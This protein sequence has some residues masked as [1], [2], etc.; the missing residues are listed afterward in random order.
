MIY[1]NLNRVKGILSARQGAEIPKFTTGGTSPIMLTVTSVQQ[2]DGKYYIN[3]DANY[4]IT[5]DEANFLQNQLA[6]S[7]K[8]QFYLD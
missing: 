4:E 6:Q 3:G 1:N 7:L 5:Q 8:L 2:R